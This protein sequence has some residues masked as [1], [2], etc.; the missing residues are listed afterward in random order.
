VFFL[1]STLSTLEWTKML[2]IGG[3]GLKLFWSGEHFVWGGTWKLIFGVVAPPCTPP[4][5]PSM[6]RR[7]PR[8]LFLFSFFLLWKPCV[9]IQQEQYTTK[10][11][12]HQKALFTQNWSWPDFEGRCG[13]RFAHLP[14]DR[15]ATPLRIFVPPLGK[16]SIID[17]SENLTFF[18]CL[19]SIHRK[20]VFCKIE[21]AYQSHS[22]LCQVPF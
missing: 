20:K 11:W 10:V 13:A 8:V 2:K 12:I 18:G 22:S 3:G 19:G 4:D 6:T 7:R 17:E 14:R 5:N 15:F 9:K 16:V 1:S 21:I